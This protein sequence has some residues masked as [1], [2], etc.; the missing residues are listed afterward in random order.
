MLNSKKRLIQTTYMVTRNK[1][2]QNNRSQYPNSAVLHCVHHMQHNHYRARIAEVYDLSTGELHA[3]I[4]RG[5]TGNITIVYR[6]E[7][8]EK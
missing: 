4:T 6:R 5:I 7:V 3:V 2:V 1:V 8:K